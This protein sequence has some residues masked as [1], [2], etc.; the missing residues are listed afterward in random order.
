MVLL[1]SVA[2]DD[3]APSLQEV[4]GVPQWLFWR[5]HGTQDGMTDVSSRNSNV[6]DSSF[7]WNSAPATLVTDDLEEESSV[8]VP[9]WLS[10]PGRPPINTRTSSLEVQP[11]SSIADGEPS[12]LRN[13]EADVEEPSWLTDAHPRRAQFRQSAAT[14]SERQ[15]FATARE[16]GY[17]EPSWLS[18]ADEGLGKSRGSVDRDSYFTAEE[19]S[20]QPSPPKVV[21]APPSNATEPS[22]AESGDED[23]GSFCHEQLEVLR[24]WVEN[25]RCMALDACGC[26][27]PTLWRNTR[28]ARDVDR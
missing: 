16:S 2:V 27:M 19:H 14:D 12:W 15:S 11:R 5:R 25:P 13:A 28:V 24:R 23:F 26:R 20:Q 10:N 9:Q 7:S 18:R 17:S 3:S 21:A 8:W 1:A 4:S 22:P 6:T